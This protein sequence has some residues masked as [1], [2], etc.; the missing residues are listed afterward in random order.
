MEDD[1]DEVTFGSASRGPPTPS[2]RA[3][4]S[5]P[6]Q[7]TPKI[8][9]NLRVDTPKAASNLRTPTNATTLQMAFDTP[10][11]D[12]LVRIAFIISVF[13]RQNTFP[14]FVC[15]KLSVI[16]LITKFCLVRQL[17]D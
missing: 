11:A 1:E 7:L 8:A 5:R 6:L 2:P 4:L 16:R 13:I 3:Q 14:K 10:A 17:F 12:K 15:Y 9:S